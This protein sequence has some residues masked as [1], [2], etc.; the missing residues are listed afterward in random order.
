MHVILLQL[1]WLLLSIIKAVSLC[2]VVQ[3][4]RWWNNVLCRFTLMR[5]KKCRNLCRVESAVTT[6]S[7]Y[8]LQVL[9]HPTLHSW[10][11]M[12][13]LGMLSMSHLTWTDTTNLF[14]PASSYLHSF[15]PSLLIL[16]QKGMYLK[17]LQWNDW[18]LSIVVIEWFARIIPANVYRYT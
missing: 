10:S 2:L 16:E 13:V 17:L 6:V 8:R 4:E 3:H 14:L 7:L 18:Q 11:S 12:T 9:F 1:P 5:S 15:L